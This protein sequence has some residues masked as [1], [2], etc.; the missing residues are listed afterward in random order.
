[1]NEQVD[2]QHFEALLGRLTDSGL[3]DLELQQL[4]R[5]IDS[6]RALRCQYLDHCQI[7]GLLR[8]EHGL[9]A[10]WD[11]PEAE[12][13]GARPADKMPSGR[14]RRALALWCAAAA[15]VGVMAIGIWNYNVDKNPVAVKP[16]N[17]YRG[18]PVARLMNQVRAQFVY[19]PSGETIPSAGA[20]IPQGTYELESGIIEIEANS[21][22]VLTIE[23]PAVFT[24]ADERSI[25]IENG[26]LAAYVP[27][28]AIGFRVETAS[29]TVVDLGTDFAVEAVTGKNSEVHVFNGEVRINLHGSK[30]SSARPLLL[31]TGKATRIDFL[32]GMPSGIDLDEQRFLRRLEIEPR[33]YTHRVLEKRP[34]AYYPMEPAGDGTLLR[35]VAPHGVDATINFGRASEPVWAPGKVGL[36]FALGGPAQQT[37]ASAAAYPQAEGDQLSVVAWVTARSRPRWASIAKNWAGA[38]NWGQ[39][40]FGLYFDS[41]E[42]EA[43]IQDDSGKEITVKDT[44]PLPLNV[45]HHV[46]FVA[47]GSMLRLYRNGREVD[48]TPYRQLRSDPRIK[49]LAIGTKLNLRGDAPE[50]RDFNMWDGR[51]DE[52]AIFNHAL[53]AD[54]VLE[55]YELASAAD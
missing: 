3:G 21:G 33:N 12:A 11:V 10:S 29:A 34:V 54:Q 43:H 53:T 36:A 18:K 52:L 5:L 20:A 51:L 6:D 17:P 41:G 27:K 44:L 16:S 42:L 1:M 48:S 37:Y 26:R 4:G 45:W 39:F 14:R 32:T 30:A 24:L 23:A 2:K 28:R 8:A 13:P 22:A 7:H 49:A 50:E 55:L 19:G 35:D 31:T 15:V 25:R 38:N 9:L 47:D 46:A 40:H